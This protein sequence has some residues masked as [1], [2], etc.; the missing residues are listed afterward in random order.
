MR[1]GRCPSG[2]I[3]D[4]KIGSCVRDGVDNIK[5]NSSSHFLLKV[6]TLLAGVAFGY[7]SLWTYGM[8]VIGCFVGLLIILL[9]VDVKLIW[10]PVIGFIIGFVVTY[11]LQISGFLHIIGVG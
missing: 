8:I 10:F 9:F 11:W 6:L 7:F 1:E 5:S 3:Y 2:Y 4:S